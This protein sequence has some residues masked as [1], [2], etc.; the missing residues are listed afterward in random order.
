MADLEDILT[1]IARDK[2]E[3]S[4]RT[5]E[6][7]IATFETLASSP[8]LGHVREDLTS[9]PVRFWG[10]ESWLIVYRIRGRAVQ[11]L[12]VLGGYQDVAAILSRPVSS[13]RG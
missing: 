12:R 5:V 4:L 9:K 13:P 10:V 2:P 11:I 8:E 1:W 3:T 6:R 7:F